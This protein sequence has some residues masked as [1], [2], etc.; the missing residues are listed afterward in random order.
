VDRVLLR[1]RLARG[2]AARLAALPVRVAAVAA[3]NGRT[4]GTSARWLAT[5]REHTNFTYDLTALN[6]GYLAWFVS[7]VAG[8]PVGEARGYLAELAGD[9]GLREHL[10]AGT[11]ASARRGLA[12]TEVRYGRRAGWYALVRACRP[13]HVVETGTDKGLGSCVLAA[14]LLRNGAG[15]LTTVDI[16][17]EAG[18]LVSGA[19]AGVVDRVT[20]DSLAGLAGLDREVDLFLHDSDH[21]AAYEAAELAAVAPH[22]SDRALVLSD[23]GEVTDELARWAEATGRRFL[24]FDERPARHWWP[25]GG[26]AAAYSG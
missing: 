7:A 13:A 25:G 18:Y 4:L 11:R 23:N 8:V 26:I 5:S 16:N 6:E 2:R 9:T 19:Y 21:A 22:L 17:P 12:D 15:R 10:T 20:G 24:Y 3:H 14:A 1:R